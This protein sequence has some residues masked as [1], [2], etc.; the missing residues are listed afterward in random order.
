M[1]FLETVLQHLQCAVCKRHEVKM[2]GDGRKVQGRFCSFS[3]CMCSL[4]M[5]WTPW[6]WRVFCRNPVSILWVLGQQNDIH[7]VGYSSLLS[8]Q[9]FLAKNK[10]QFCSEWAV[11]W[12]KTRVSSVLCGQFSVPKQGSVLFCVVRVFWQKTRVSSVLSGQFSGKKQGSVL[13]W[14]GSFLAKNKG[15]FCSVWAVFWPKT[16]GS[17]VLSGQFSGQKQGSVLFWVGS[18]PAKYKG[19]FCSVWAVL[20]PKT[21][22]SCV[23]CWWCVVWGYGLCMV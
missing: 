3:S 8:G 22:V 19:Q 7:C 21:R 12:P 23:A 20:W 16:R 18:F 11:F 15:Q 1:L 10:G 14:V 6:S 9:S 5:L 2:W 4:D 13:F 17:S